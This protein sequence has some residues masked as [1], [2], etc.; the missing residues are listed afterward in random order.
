MILTALIPIAI[1]QVIGAGVLAGLQR[2]T[3]SVNPVICAAEGV[4][5]SQRN[6]S[7]GRLQGEIRSRELCV[8]NAA[9]IPGKYVLSIDRDIVLTDENTLADMIKAL[10]SEPSTGCIA[11]WFGRCAKTTVYLPH[12]SLKCCLFRR[13][14]FCNLDFTKCQAG[15]TCQTVKQQVDAQGYKG[16][17]FEFIRRGFELE[18]VD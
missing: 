1:G 4:I 12:I 7:P 17:Y 13:S 11:L 15:C 5:N 6:Y 10:D 8:A 18:M 16:R 9:N 3:V 2:Q 14:V